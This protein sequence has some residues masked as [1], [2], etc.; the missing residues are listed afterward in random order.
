MKKTKEK[1]KQPRISKK[2]L[3]VFMSLVILLSGITEALYCAGRIE[4]VVALL[5]WVPAVSAFIASGVAMADNKDKFNP[6]K[7]FR[8]SGIRF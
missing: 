8:Y 3:T 4:W 7:L 5:M 2:A 1:F 6:I